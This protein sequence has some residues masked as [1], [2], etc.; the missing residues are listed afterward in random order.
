MGGVDMKELESEA[1]RLEPKA[2]AR[3]A[4][5]PLRSLE[6]LSEAEIETAWADEA[7]SRDAEV[8]SDPSALRSA[9]EV[10]RDARSKRR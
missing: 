5:S 8:D 3:L 7:A 9:S 6:Q 10:L 4:A 2:R 1:L